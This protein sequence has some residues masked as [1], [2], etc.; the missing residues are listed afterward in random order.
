[1]D[2]AKPAYTARLG[3]IWDA[4]AEDEA[5]AAALAA[6]AAAGV[7]QH[8]LPR[9]DGA[10]LKLMRKDGR[11]V[12]YHQLSDLCLSVTAEPHIRSNPAAADTGFFFITLHGIAID[13][14]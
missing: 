10:T 1:M 5:T 6:D 12:Q 4:I 3:E 13:V 8:V 7:W 2:I 11:K 9:K 14:Y